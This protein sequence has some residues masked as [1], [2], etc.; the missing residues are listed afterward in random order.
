MPAEAP[1]SGASGSTAEPG[2]GRPAPD[3]SVVLPSFNSG[4]LIRRAMD[5]V[6]AQ[7]RADLEI[8]IVDDASTDGSRE[9]I[10]AACSRDSRVRS[11]ALSS[12]GGPARARNVGFEAARGRW[13]ALIDADDAWRPDRLERL[14][15]LLGEEADAVFDNLVGYDFSLGA[16]TGILFP[17]FPSGSLSAE[18]LLA[19]RI[20]GSAFD[21]GYLKP[22]IRRAFVQERG[23]RYDESLRTGED[24]VFYLMLLLEGARTRLTDEALYLYTTPMGQVSGAASAISHTRP[25]DERVCRA[26]ERIAE[27]HAT[28][29]DAASGRAIR[30]LIRHMR[31]ERPKAEF[32][33]AR[34]HGR[35]LDMVSI[36]LREP[37]VIADVFGKAL[38]RVHARLTGSKPV[39]N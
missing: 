33:H 6:L 19:P 32:Y 13:L 36:A 7:T 4:A 27:S 1:R 16:E 38:H 30:E 24:R 25:D 31:A 26:L 22:L 15:P 21:F 10:E 20:A 12:N 9:A 2:S 29:I 39:R 5:S 11:I 37:A 28:R 35:V 17:Q 23:L 3:V 14:A 34:A 18:L 8:V